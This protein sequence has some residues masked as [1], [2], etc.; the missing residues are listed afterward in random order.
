M[1]FFIV[2]K[3]INATILKQHM[4]AKKNQTDSKRIKF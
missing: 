1:K 4:Q 3:T 2:Q